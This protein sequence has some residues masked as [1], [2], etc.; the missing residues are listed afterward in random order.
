[1]IIKK[2]LKRVPYNDSGLTLLSHVICAHLHEP[3]V[4]EET[5]CGGGE[6]TCSR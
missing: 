5:T 3:S 4:G 1:M 2:N 6:G